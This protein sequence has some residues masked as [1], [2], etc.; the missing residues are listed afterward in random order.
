MS[1]RKRRHQTAADGDEEE[2]VDDLAVAASFAMA[3]LVGMAGDGGNANQE[4]E[5]TSSDDDDEES[6][7]DDDDEE[8]P[9]EDEKAGGKD[10]DNNTYANDEEKTTEESPAKDNNVNGVNANDN[11]KEDSDSD[12]ESDVDLSEALARMV[13]ESGDEAGASDDEGAD[14]GGRRR[15]A[16]GSGRRGKPKAESSTAP[17]RT[18]NEIDPYACPVSVLE[19]KLAIDLRVDTT[20]SSAAGQAY[21]AKADTTAPNKAT[22][23]GA[24]DLQLCPAGRVKNHLVK[25]RTIVVESGLGMVTFASGPLDE[26]SLLVVRAGTSTTSSSSSSGAEAPEAGA[27]IVPL[28]RVFEVF[29]P[30]KQ[31]LYTIRLLSPKDLVRKAPPKPQPT[32]TAGSTSAEAEA[33]DDT[34]KGDADADD[35]AIDLDEDGEEEQEE[36]KMANG[37]EAKGA[38]ATAIP[39]EEAKKDEDKDEVKDKGKE[40]EADPWAE[41]GQHT[42]LLRD[43]PN[44]E[45][46]F[47]RDEAKLIDTNNVIKLSG[48]GCDASNLY[49][50]ELNANEIDFSDDEEERMAKRKAKD[51]RNAKRIDGQQQRGG[52]GGRGGRGT[53][54]RG[55]RGRNNGRGR[56]GWGCHSNFHHHQYQQPPPVAMTMAPTQPQM[57]GAPPMP[58][59]NQYPQYGAQH[60]QQQMPY[61]QQ[62]QPPMPMHP[63]GF[64]QMPYPQYQQNLPNMAPPPPQHQPYAGAGGYVVQAPQQYGTGMPGGV[65]PPPPPPQGAYQVQP[66]N[67]PGYP[68][69]QLQMQGQQQMPPYPVPHSQG[70]GQVAQMQQ[71]QQQQQQEGGDTV[72]YDYGN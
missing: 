44:I 12:D 69:Q 51:R 3:G 42:K 45:V 33:G 50:E 49:D 63:Q 55:G 41:D 52:P 59:G 57:M 47:V 72:Y 2:T 34:K 48:R 66:P 4:E 15:G 54:G 30:V 25:E 8:E 9:S 19:E 65:P 36:E 21:G 14:G 28:G 64:Q 1:Q 18:E 29:G 58:Y 13:G 62:G 24:N 7:E 46:Y 39:Q 71:Q 70:Q 38:D 6:S 23:G 10:A 61:M 35:N 5:D 27:A 16:R 67:Y 60:P 22:G 40:E 17:L 53:G 32:E 37:D 26:G 20:S 11:A 56:G 68:S 31:P 43:Q